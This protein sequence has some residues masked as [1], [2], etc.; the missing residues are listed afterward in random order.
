MRSFLSLATVA[1]LALV[2]CDDPAPADP[3]SGVSLSRGGNAPVARA[4]GGGTADIQDLGR[5]KYAF[6]ATVNGD[7]EVKGTFDLHF[8]TIDAEA[9]GDITCLFVS[10]NRATMIGRVDRAT[11]PDAAA[12]SPFII[13]SVVDNGEGA[14][15]EPDRVSSF[16]PSGGTFCRGFLGTGTEWTN[17]NVQ[18]SGATP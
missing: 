8:T 17:G 2:A 6:H 1:A 14:N 15:A 4:S 10:G 5:S 3:V 11:G 13:W 18:V 16:S 7:G 9:H 12:I